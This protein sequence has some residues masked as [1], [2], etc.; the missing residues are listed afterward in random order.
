MSLLFSK[1]RLFERKETGFS[2]FTQ[3]LSS[4]VC[5]TH[6]TGGICI[7]VEPQKTT[8]NSFPKPDE[9][10]NGWSLHCAKWRDAGVRRFWPFR[11]SFA[12]REWTDIFSRA[13]RE[14]Q[15]D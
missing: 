5:Q 12:Q 13:S 14:K 15:N 1:P 3:E 6:E 7:L 9:A 4:R 11:F 10:V 8:I 2:F